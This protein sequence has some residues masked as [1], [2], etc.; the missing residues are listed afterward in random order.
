[1]NDNTY[2]LNK[3]S[4]GLVVMIAAFLGA[5]LF[6]VGDLLVD[7]VSEPTSIE[8]TSE[9]TA[10]QEPDLADAIHD[11]AERAVEIEGGKYKGETFE[12]AK[13]ELTADNPHITAYRVILQPAD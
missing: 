9:E 4:L 3:V 10:E 8:G 11:A 1:M 6:A 7:E 5:L 2:R 13:I 12:I